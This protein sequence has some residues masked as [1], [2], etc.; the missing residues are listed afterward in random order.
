[1]NLRGTV[2]AQQGN[3]AEAETYFLRA[4]CLD[5]KL[6]GVHMNLAHLYL[7]KGAPTKTIGE[8]KEVLRLE[9]ANTDAMGRLAEVLFSQGQFD[10]C[11]NVIEMARRTSTPP[12][13]LLLMLGDAYIEKRNPTKAEENYQQVLTLD[14]ENTDAIL[15]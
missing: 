6:P 8:L 7:L 3:I 9:P 11:I 15:G 10:E 14:T 13:S 1:F 4:A 2:R 12:V 5:P